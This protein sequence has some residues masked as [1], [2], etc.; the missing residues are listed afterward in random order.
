[1]IDS[2]II[3]K[4]VTDITRREHGVHDRKLIHP[5]REWLVGMTVVCCLVVAGGGVS[6]FLYESTSSDTFLES[7]ATVMTVPYHS[8]VVIS[9][10]AVYAKRRQQFDQQVTGTNRSEPS[11]VHTDAPPASVIPSIA[12]SSTSVPHSSSL[13]TSTITAF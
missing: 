6:Y 9:A 13:P 3:K 8:D 1:M 4:M 7:A 12:T 5:V 11:T 10:N 2:N